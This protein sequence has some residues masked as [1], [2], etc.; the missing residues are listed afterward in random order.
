MIP[1]LL[2]PALS[3]RLVLQQPTQSNSSAAK[4]PATQT[5]APT[6]AAPTQAAGGQAGGGQAPAAPPDVDTHPPAVSGGTPTV[7]DQATLSAPGWIEFDPGVLKDLQRDDLFGTPLTFKFTTQNNRLQYLLGSDGYVRLDPSTTGIGDTYPGVHYLLLN[8][9]KYGFDVAGKFILKVPTAPASLGG[10]LRP[11]YSAYVLA[12]RDFTKWG[13]HGDFNAGAL[14]LSRQGLPGYD[15]QWMITGSTTT[16][17]PGGR[18]QY[19]NELVYFSGIAG[20]SYHLAMMH[21]F[22]YS[23]HRYATYSAG[24]QVA[25]HGDLPKYQFLFAAS[26]NFA[27]PESHASKG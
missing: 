2:I 21:G 6:Q 27:T 17:I 12:S 9:Q 10:T 8:Q 19:S 3:F 24:L 5:A 4:S 15:K 11:D 1:L 22:S 16:S 26:F 14:E 18:W 20:D 23:A 13:F 7:T 25:M